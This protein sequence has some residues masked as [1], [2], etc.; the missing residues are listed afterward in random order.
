MANKRKIGNRIH[1]FKARKFVRKSKPQTPEEPRPSTSSRSKEKLDHNF[2]LYDNRNENL[3]YEIIDVSILKNILSEVAV[4][5]LCHGTLSL[6]KTS[7]V[8]LI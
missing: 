1:A 3:E 7:T 8:G 2:S 4:C 5:K 6:S